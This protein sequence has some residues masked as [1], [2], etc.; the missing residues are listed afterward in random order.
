MPKWESE[1]RKRL[2]GLKLDPAR[3]VEIVEELALHLENRYEE[4]RAGGATDKEAFRAAMTELVE[5]DLFQQGL[6]RVERPMAEE[7]VVLGT[8]RRSNMI[9]DL[10]QDLGYGLRMLRKHAGFTA[11]AVMTLALGIGANVAVFSVVNAVLLRP[12]PYPEP[13]RLVMLQNQ[14]LA[15]NLKNAGVSAAD[16]A[17][18]RK[19][20]HIFEEVAAG[21]GGSLNLSGPALADRPESVSGAFVTAGL[22]PLLGIRPVA[23][24]FFSEDEDR[25]GYNQVVVLS[26]G[27]WKRRF[28]GDPGVVGRTLQLSDQSY[29]VIGVI[30]P[31][32]E[33]LGPNEV[34][35]PAAFT[36]EQMNPGRRS[37]RSLFAMARLK[38]DVSLAQ[39]QAE[40]NMFAQALAKEF[41]ND[42]PAESGWGIRVD[43]LRELWV[44]EVRLALWILMGAVGF[45][46][47]IAC[48]NV[49]NLLL[50]RATVR[51]REISIRSALG[52]D[53]WRIARQLLTENALLGL[54]G[55]GA[56]LLLAFW[57]IELL[58][59]VGPRNFP[60]LREIGIDWPVLG[61]TLGISLLTALLAGLAPLLEAT[62]RNL[63]E[64]LKESTRGGGGGRRQNRVRRLLVVAEVA[65][66][67]ILLIVAGLLLQSFVRLQRV[68]PGFQ[69]QNALTFRVPLSARRY[70][71]QA[72]RV[73]FID[74]L[75]ERVRNLPGVTAVGA[76]SM[77]PFIGTNS[78]SV[79]GIEGRDV[80]PGGA[81][82]HADIRRVTHGFF[83][84][85]G[86]PL[87][88]GR[89]F[90][91]TD[92]AT[93]PFVAL[94]GE[95]LAEQYWTGEDPV[96]KRVKMGGP[97][98]PWYTIVG[99]VGHVK[100]S[101][102][103]GE[104]KGALYFLYSQNRAFMITLVVRTS[105]APEQL[106]GVVQQEVSAIDKD[107]PV[108]EVK[109][110]NERLLDSLTTQRLAAYLAAV[111]AGVALLLAA[112][113]IYGV[114]SHSV[115]Q[116]TNE[117]GIRMALGAQ[118]GDVLKQVLWQGL[119]LTVIGAG[120]G[121][122]S[123]LA[124]TH[125]MSNL[126]F[127]VSATDPVT[128]ASI[129]LLL[130]AV[131][132]L[133]CYIPAR[134]AAQVDPLVALRS[135]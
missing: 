77:L 73:A 133:A 122:I 119:V 2:A 125:L 72:Q 103:N 66:S 26:E 91:E 48:V 3:E 32:P 56:G 118:A 128:F 132:L 83:E 126:L 50:G 41:P 109:T 23:G 47:L 90:A 25:P 127:E 135:E 35:M 37:G 27:F 13:D 60:R 20:T 115:S 85:I 44:G 39:A 117:I 21:S 17:D 12:L 6:R 71:E 69:P 116:R 36:P 42:Y 95:K 16:Y 107:V 93:T 51:A 113:G 8:S 92:I 80:S 10:W 5:N 7:P 15:R 82:P 63:H 54:L 84:A 81:S 124:L 1:I 19:Q 134:R 49:T 101:Q 87:R 75:I 61:F 28:G 68:D 131:A 88:R 18:Y 45:V 22:F 78:S 31:A 62:R 102:L 105:N 96:S 104:S 74:R 64:G 40:M 9:G 34:F 106:A 129:T 24:R 57:G 33:V 89:L 4:L 53:A 46:L 94:L 58:R 97:Q 76:T 29:T 11:I 43:S 38:R 111:F 59:Q 120:A 100:H 52:A 99:V 108:Y 14:F 55:G 110:M 130:V 70:P 65:L 114:M 98:S 86:I 121:L 79:F 30:P 123:A 112:L 67:L